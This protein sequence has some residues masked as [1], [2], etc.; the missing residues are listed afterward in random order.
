MTPSRFR[1]EMSLTTAERHNKLKHPLRNVR[2]HNYDETCPFHVI[3]DTII[4]QNLS[5][6]TIYTLQLTI[7]NKDTISRCLKMKIEESNHISVTNAM[8]LHFIKLAPGMSNVY[9]VNYCAVDYRDYKY[10]IEFL[11]EDMSFVV[12]IFGTCIFIISTLESQRLK[13]YSI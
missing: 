4:F 5:L 7:T 3:P 8:D 2:L 10:E 6:N 12:P 13:L 11:T 9:N 1:D